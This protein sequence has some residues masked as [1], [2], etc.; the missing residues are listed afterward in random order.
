[1]R[2]RNAFTMTELIFVIVVIGILAAIAIPNIG[3]SVVQAQIASAKADVMALRSAILNERQKRL[4][5]GQNDFIATLS[6]GSTGDG[7]AL[8]DGD[9]TRVLFSYPRISKSASG[10]WVRGGV[11]AAGGTETYTFRV[12]TTPVVFTYFRNNGT[13]TCNRNAGGSAGTYCR[14]ITE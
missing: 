4:M 8:F 6:S 1:M 14:A 7:Q 5:R 12:D 3:G 13:F 2:L 11:G 9:G 10:K